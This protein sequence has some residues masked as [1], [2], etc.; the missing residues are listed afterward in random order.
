MNYNRRLQTPEG[1]SLS[2][3]TPWGRSDTVS[4]W[5][6]GLD[7]FTTPSHGGFRL[8]VERWEELN[9]S[10]AFKSWAGPFWLE[11]DEDANL[12][13]IRWPELFPGQ[14]VFFAVRYVSKEPEGG[15]L[16]PLYPGW[17]DNMADARRWLKSDAGLPA[18][19][20]AYAFAEVV[21]GQWERGGLATCQAGWEVFF[22]RDGKQRRVIF[23][24][25]PTKV[26]YTDAELAAVQPQPLTPS[27]A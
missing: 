27:K 12:A 16:A 7:F 14:W 23:P 26:F 24:E 18:R 6:P 11:E 5:G 17:R 2:I 1:C 13:V 9:A 10:F 3:E 8:S 25:Y 4:N 21:K 19:Q 15:T 22:Y 20:I